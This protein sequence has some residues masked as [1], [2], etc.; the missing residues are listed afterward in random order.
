MWKCNFVFVLTITD[1]HTHTHIKS[2]CMP[3]IIVHFSLDSI[4][5]YFLHCFKSIQVHFTLFSLTNVTNNRF[6]YCLFIL[7]WY[8]HS[9][10]TATCGSLHISIATAFITK[11][12]CSLL[13]N[14]YLSRLLHIATVLCSLG[15]ITFL[16]CSFVRCKFYPSSSLSNQMIY[17]KQQ[18][19]H[20]F[21][22]L[23]DI[24]V[25]HIKCIRDSFH[26][27]RSFDLHCMYVT[28]M[29]ERTKNAYY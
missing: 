19:G 7:R 28:I 14:V 8:D 1:T 27:H 25:V 13:H 21:A 9:T 22:K 15:V 26:I 29:C 23:I 17:Q 11:P 24:I 5:I 10:R 16:F 4:V 3:L 12:I 2:D 6:A 20:M 18:N